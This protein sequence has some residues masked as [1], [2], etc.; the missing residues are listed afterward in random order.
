MGRYNCTGEQVYNYTMVQ[1]YECSTIQVY[2]SETKRHVN[3]GTG[4]QMY[5]KRDSKKWKVLLHT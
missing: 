1:L 2:S 5:N 4:E 3:K